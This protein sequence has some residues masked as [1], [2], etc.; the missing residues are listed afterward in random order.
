MGRGGCES[1]IKDGGILGSHCAS[2]G[3]RR[4]IGV[5]TEEA[6]A[7]TRGLR[8]PGRTISGRFR[9]REQS[10]CTG[11]PPPHRVFAAFPTRCCACFVLGSRT[12]RGQRSRR[13]TLFFFAVQSIGRDAIRLGR[14]SSARDAA[15]RVR[16]RS[17]DLR[18]QCRKGRSR[19]MGHSG[20]RGSKWAKDSSMIPVDSRRMAR[21]YLAF[22]S[23]CPRIILLDAA[24]RASPRSSHRPLPC[25]CSAHP[26]VST[27]AFDLPR[28]VVPR[29]R[30]GCLCAGLPP[31]S[32]RLSSTSASPILLVLD[33][34]ERPRRDRLPG[35][36]RPRVEGERGASDLPIE[37]SRA[38]A[39]RLEAGWS[40][41]RS[42]QPAGV[43]LESRSLPGTSH[44]HG[45]PGRAAA[46]VYASRR[47]EEGVLYGVVQQ[48][49]ETFL[50]GAS[51]RERPVPRFVARELRAFCAAESLPMASCACTATAADS[52]AASPS[53]AR[54]AASARRAAVP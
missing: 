32:Q 28:R 13:H 17:D 11:R 1:K 40:R 18:V 49:L 4:R 19:A 23:F 12:T 8:R 24:S 31:L 34:V 29:R 36:R 44:S 50:A 21:L 26:L 10:G 35:D 47:P 39:E 7:S 20:P 42:W 51:T 41:V 46:R 54:A 30:S 53:R 25:R 9:R 16:P 27:D 2:S 22:A 3:I 38:H 45:A 43:G 6:S 5:A 15:R 48:E 14:L 33:V 52:T 37:R